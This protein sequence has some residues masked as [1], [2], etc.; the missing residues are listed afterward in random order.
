MM[1]QPPRRSQG[2]APGWACS[3]GKRPPFVVFV[4][5]CTMSLITAA[6][7]T[8]R[9]V[10]PTTIYWSLVPLVEM[11][12]I[13]DRHYRDPRGACNL[14][15]NC[16]EVRTMTAGHLTVVFLLL[17][18]I[19]AGTIADVP[20]KH[21]PLVLRGYHVLT[22]DFHVHSFPLSWATL[23]PWDTVID[24]QH[25]GLE[26]MAMTGAQPRVGC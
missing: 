1:Q 13:I 3:P 8:L 9:L 23:A 21:P 22:A 10:E 6:S 19:V 14:A 17:T 12:D 4:L 20:H 26:V 5:G 7:L 24:A 18:A 15:G 16:W 25:Q 2:T 11:L